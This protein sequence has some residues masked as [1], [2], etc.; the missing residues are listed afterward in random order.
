MILKQW[1]WEIINVCWRKNSSGVDVINFNG[2]GDYMIP[3]T[4]K[5]Y[6]AGPY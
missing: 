4:D 6:I 1:G 3:D 5:A 2:G